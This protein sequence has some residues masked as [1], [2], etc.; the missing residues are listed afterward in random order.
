MHYLHHLLINFYRLSQY[1][2]HDENTN[3][4]K[5][6]ICHSSKGTALGIVV[7]LENTADL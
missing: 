2:Q 4:D 5:C 3:L 6:N 7:I 1:E